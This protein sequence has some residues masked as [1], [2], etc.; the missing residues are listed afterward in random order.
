[1]VDLT[2]LLASLNE[3][4]SSG[5]SKERRSLVLQQIVGFFMEHLD[6]KEDEVAIFFT[7]RQKTTLSFAYP[8]YLVDSGIIQINSPDAVVAQIYR[9][10]EPFLDNKFLE[11][12]HL[13]MFEFIKTPQSETKLIW[14]MMG[15]QIAHKGEAFGVIEISRRRL[16]FE[17]VGRDFTRDDL[18]F[19]ENSIFQ[20]SGIF[21]TLYDEIFKLKREKIRQDLA[22][23]AE[24]LRWRRGVADGDCV[25]IRNTYLGI[26]QICKG[27]VTHK[28]SIDRIEVKTTSGNCKENMTV[29]VDSLWPCSWDKSKMGRAVNV[30]K[31]LKKLS[32]LVGS[33]D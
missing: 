5:S 17:E 2:R 22:L 18:S 16:S 32:K 25:K 20:L 3:E 24:I 21:K 15:I 10:G 9:T 14:K 6:V 23:L 30:Y 11:K 13:S 27:H 12:D 4:L 26:I 31:R 1:M 7:N 28:Y 19:L 8:E 33:S 29:S